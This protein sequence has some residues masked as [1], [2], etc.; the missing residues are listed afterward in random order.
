MMITLI[1]IGIEFSSYTYSDILTVGY[2]SGLPKP[3]QVI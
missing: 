1:T 3:I 2:F